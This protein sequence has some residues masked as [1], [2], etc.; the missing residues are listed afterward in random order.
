MQNLLVYTYMHHRSTKFHNSEQHI[1]NT[2]LKAETMGF[3][4][5]GWPWDYCLS[6]YEISFSFIWVAVE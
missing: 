1:F 5:I 4:I 3:I 2:E 6:T